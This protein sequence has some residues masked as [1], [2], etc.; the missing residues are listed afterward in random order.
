MRHRC[1]SLPAIL[2]ATLP[3]AA[4]QEI[5]E[6]I[7]LDAW[8]ASSFTA[9][10]G[11]SASTTA[12]THDASLR[13][14][15]QPTERLWATMAQRVDEEGDLT[16]SEAYGSVQV[17]DALSVSSG[18]TYGPFGYYGV[19]PVLI[20]TI[21]PA[22]TVDLYTSSPVGVWA[23]YEASDAFN[24]T[25][26]L[27]DTYFFA[28][29]A[30]R[31]AS[32]SPGIDLV[33]LP[34]P[35]LTLNLEVAIDPNGGRTDQ[36]GSVGDV[37]WGGV[38]AEFRRDALLVA[39]EFLYQVVE[40]NGETV[41][42]DDQANFAWAAFATYAIPDLSIPM[43]AT[44]Q[45]SGF[46]SGATQDEDGP[47][48]DLVADDVDAT[49]ATKAQLALLTN[50]LVVSQFGLNLELFYRIDDAGGGAD[51]IDSYGMAVEG[52]WVLP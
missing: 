41:G 12:F 14:G 15:W 24:A 25:F 27:A 1:I 48:A 3:A 39:G 6:S 28:N 46:S 17:S 42:A 44:A 30:N 51:K 5:S 10:T 36:D 37:F 19:E 20:T 31:P 16:V 18:M 29:K 22:L 2:A 49:R 7:T 26:M 40:N 34:I 33:Y 8:V 4:A 43:A 23:T 35:E 13:L 11:D 21:T 45:I 9:T 50:P 52:L 38:N 47:D 32:V